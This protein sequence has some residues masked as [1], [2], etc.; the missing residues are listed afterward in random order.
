[1]SKM[2]QV[3]LFRN[4]QVSE[5]IR[6]YWLVDETNPGQSMKRAKPQRHDFMNYPFS[7][8]GVFFGGGINDP[9]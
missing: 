3:K 8:P 7:W 1:M 2:A 6:E 4:V 5:T 9:L